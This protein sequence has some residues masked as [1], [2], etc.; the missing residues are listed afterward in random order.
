MELFSVPGD[1]FRMVGCDTKPFPKGTDSLS[2]IQQTSPGAGKVPQCLY[3]SLSMS[4]SSM[5]TAIGKQ[6]EKAT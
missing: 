5:D 3:S 4:L 1:D 2:T 6:L